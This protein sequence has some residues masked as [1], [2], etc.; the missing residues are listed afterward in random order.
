MSKK[1]GTSKKRWEIAGNIVMA[2]LSI[3]AIIPFILLFVSSL[4]SEK[5]ALTY[6]YQFW[7]M[8][9]SL[10]AYIYLLN[11]WQSIG[12]AYLITLIITVIGTVA[13]LVIASTFAFVLSRKGLP[14][15]RFIS[16]LV[17]FTM[18]FNGGACSTYII[19]TQ[20][21]HI[22]DTI[23]ALIIPGLLLNAYNVM[24]FRNYFEN[25]IPQALLEAAKIDGA[26]EVRSFIK[27]VIPLSLPMFTTVGLTLV[28]GYW[29]DW[30]NA[31]YYVSGNHSELLSIQAYLNKVNE[32]IKFL[33]SNN[34]I[35][36]DIDTSSLPTTTIRMAIGVIGV[37]PILALYPFFQKWFVR[38]ITAGA[39]KE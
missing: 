32:N 36:Q 4:T 35:G 1:R 23:W 19:Y 3:S 24:L 21:F 34:T 38:G 30:T 12:H 31:M 15:R 29:N 10:D 33:A 2:I 6:G 9:W 39:V 5:A 13:G 18:L 14:G 25:S 17:V 28:L 20:V 22:K 26:S 16:F 37:V 27:I 7:P 11:K 8:E